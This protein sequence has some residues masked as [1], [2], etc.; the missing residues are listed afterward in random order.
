MV[1]NPGVIP[2]MQSVRKG[3]IKRKREMIL[4]ILQGCW[5]SCIDPDAKSHVPA[6]IHCAQ[7]LGIPL[8]L[9]F[10]MPWSSTKAFPHPL[11]NLRES[12]V[13]AAVANALSYSIV[14]WMTWRGY[15]E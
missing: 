6:H 1:E 11:A 4:D 3:D 10:T 9:M 7:A 14:D 12:K 8:H 5:S 13:D 2:S 15:N